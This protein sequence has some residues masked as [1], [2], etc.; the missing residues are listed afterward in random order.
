MKT[1]DNDRAIQL[2]E[3]IFNTWTTVEKEGDAIYHSPSNWS[4][5]KRSMKL[6]K[7]FDAL[8]IEDE[9]IIEH[10]DTLEQVLVNFDVAH[11]SFEGILFRKMVYAMLALALLVFASH[12]NP[13][14]PDINPQDWVT[15]EPTGLSATYHSFNQKKTLADYP[16]VIPAGTQLQPLAVVND[17]AQVRT[18]DGNFGFVL[19]KTLAGSASVV[20]KE[21]TT[22][23]SLPNH[24]GDQTTLTSG[25]EATYLSYVSEPEGVPNSAQIRL[26]DGATGYINAEGMSYAMLASLPTL[27]KS[28]YV[29]LS[30]EVA[31]EHVVGHTVEEI[32]ARYGPA[33]SVVPDG[34]GNRIAYFD[35]LRIVKDGAVSIQVQATLNPLGVVTSW[36]TEYSTNDVYSH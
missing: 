6:L 25:T 34:N 24:K 22:M 20:I 18:P 5:Y 7:R 36:K 15:T 4:E 16:V 3:K 2:L 12:L 26:A 13:F 11:P 32:E 10:R 23:Y 30:P 9:D 19:C 27:V 8:G 29:A 28:R 14:H 35:N 33:E 17:K 31:E 1:S 21:K